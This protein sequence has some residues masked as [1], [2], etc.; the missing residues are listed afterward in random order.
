M[1]E[2]D[3]S[4]SRGYMQ[5]Q[6]V[7]VFVHENGLGNAPS[8]KL[9]ARLSVKRKDGVEAARSIDDYSISLASADLPAGVEL[10]DLVG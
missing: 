10:V 5:M 3:R 8:G 2:I 6:K 9:F 7:V 1:F 4:A